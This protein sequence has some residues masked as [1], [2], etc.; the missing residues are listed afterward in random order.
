VLATR[1]LADRTG[2]AAVG[3]GASFA[4]VYCQLRLVHARAGVVVRVAEGVATS[5]LRNPQYPPP[6]DV[7]CWD[8]KYQSAL[9]RFTKA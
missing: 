7:G 9:A 1:C 5:Y 2:P 8:L 3:C 6:Q 4:P